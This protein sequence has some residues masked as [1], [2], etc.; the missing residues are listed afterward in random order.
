MFAAEFAAD[1]SGK[2]SAVHRARWPGG[3]G[4]STIFNG[5]ENT[6]AN[7]PVRQCLW[8]RDFAAAFEDGGVGLTFFHTSQG[9]SIKRF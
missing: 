5:Q 1:A 4:N 9:Y 7:L 2:Y 8:T 6:L 3:H